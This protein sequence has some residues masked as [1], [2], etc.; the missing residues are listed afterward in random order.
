VACV[1]F[2]FNFQYKDFVVKIQHFITVVFIISFLEMILSFIELSYF[3][4]EGYRSIV[5][6]LIKMAL[7]LLRNTF[8]RVICILIS[9][10]YGI[11]RPNVEEHY[12]TIGLLSF[13]YF[14]S[15]V[16]YL[17][18]QQLNQYKYLQFLK[19]DNSPKD[20]KSL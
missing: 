4:S 16:A 5:L 20:L 17:A 1:W 3:N 19:L 7:N 8:A 18:V 9:L 10:G 14:V 15:G 6:V 2:Y 12:G 13:L 11:V